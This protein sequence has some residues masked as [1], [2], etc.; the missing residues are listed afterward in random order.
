MTSFLGKLAHIISLLT[1]LVLTLASLLSPPQFVWDA[2][3]FSHDRHYIVREM[4]HEP[5]VMGVVPEPTLDDIP[6]LVADLKEAYATGMTRPLSARKAALTGLRNMVTENEAAFVAA[7]HADLGRPEFEALYYD[8]LLPLSEIDHLLAHVDEWAAPHRVGPSIVTFPSS[9]L[10]YK[11]PYGTVLVIGTWNYPFMLSL[12]PAA[13]AIAAGN[14]VLLKPC[15]VSS[16][17]ANLMAQLIPQYVDPAFLSVV[18][19][20]M[21]G[22]RSTTA[23]LLTHRFDYIFFT[24]SPSVGRVI[25]RG[26]AEF[27]TPVTLEL[28]G[29]NPVF[30][31][32]SADIVKAAKSLVWSRN[33]NA[34]QQCIS[35]DTVF[36]HHDVIDQFEDACKQ[37]IA[38]FY[39][40]DS[41]YGRIVGDKQ[42]DRIAHMLQDSGGRIIEGGIIDRDERH[43]SPTVVRIGLDSSAMQD[44]T[45]GPILWITPVPSMDAA[46]DFVNTMPK[47]L[48]MYIFA[49]DQ[50]VAQQ[51]VANTSAGGVTING[52]LFHVGHP[53]LP[54]GGVGDSG[55]GAY[56][57][58]AS[59]DLF[60]HQKP[61]LRKLWLPDFG[62]LSD[63]FFLYPPFSSLKI[64][65]LRLIAKLM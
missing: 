63:P 51:I 57:G 35:P 28:G 61:V 25:M 16:A 43:F 8:V 14:N 65:L 7:L 39:T 40:D 9:D 52:T 38:T 54:F 30:V 64:S 6:D 32:A 56:H 4:R 11:E 50:D 24:G 15:N 1:Q 58:K 2:L 20:A 55:M 45:F 37:W 27:L 47:P 5:R 29:K 34:G 13:A 36:V 44:E 41:Q 21:K 49:Q 53:N 42:M 59:F 12:V 22:D 62:A 19:T 60:T 26:A 23:E 31:D 48:A 10:V 3:G 33:F 46:I 18:G 17:C